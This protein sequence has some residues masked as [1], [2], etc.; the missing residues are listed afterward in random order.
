MNLDAEFAKRS[1]MR[2]HT[3]FALPDGVHWYSEGEFCGYF[4]GIKCKKSAN[5][6]DFNIN[7]I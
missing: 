4:K 2:I 7:F 5:N 6:V 1:E 3:H